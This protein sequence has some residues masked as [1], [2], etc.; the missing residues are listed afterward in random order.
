MTDLSHGRD[1]DNMHLAPKPD[2]VSFCS[3]SAED[4]GRKD[5]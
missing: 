3:D 2:A 5:T 4:Y 1:M